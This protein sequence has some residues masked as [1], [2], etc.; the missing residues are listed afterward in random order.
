MT[1]DRKDGP[2]RRKNQGLSDEEIE[3]I[4][5]Q[6]LASIYEDIGRSVVKKL[7]WALG[8]VLAAL[9]AW[10]TARGYLK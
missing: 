4:K 9:L 7:L 2:E 10:A 6:L 1:G 8:A 3:A 5:E